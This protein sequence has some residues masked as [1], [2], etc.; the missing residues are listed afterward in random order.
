MVK[1]QRAGLFA[2]RPGIAFR[3]GE[4]VHFAM[5]V[6]ALLAL[7]SLGPVRRHVFFDCEWLKSCCI[8]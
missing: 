7:A 3:F 6:L 2:G 8:D 5:L 4:E 1:H